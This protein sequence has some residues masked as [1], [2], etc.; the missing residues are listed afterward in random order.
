MLIG[1]VFNVLLYGLMI[2]QVYIYYTTYKEFVSF[3]Q[4]LV[5]FLTV[6]FRDEHW[7]K[8]FVHALP[9]SKSGRGTN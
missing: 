9:P 3:F 8:A 5:S 2:A 1:F 7:M 4:M 6:F